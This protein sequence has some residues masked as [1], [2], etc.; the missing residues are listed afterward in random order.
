M[1]PRRDPMR[2]ILRTVFTLGLLAAAVL[3][4]ACLSYADFWLLKFLV[5]GAI[6]L[7]FTA[8]S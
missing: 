7:C 6:T 8:D 1:P 3:A 4:F 2:P 5:A